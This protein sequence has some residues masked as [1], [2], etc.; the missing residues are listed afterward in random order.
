MYSLVRCVGKARPKPA[1]DLGWEGVGGEVM[2]KTG[3]DL[4]CNPEY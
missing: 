1:S 3:S 2:S 4:E